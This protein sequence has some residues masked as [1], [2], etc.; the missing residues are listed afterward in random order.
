M[1]LDLQ[2]HQR[3]LKPKPCAH[4]IRTLNQIA[5]LFCDKINKKQRRNMQ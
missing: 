1:K 5:V 3:D 4:V 2:L